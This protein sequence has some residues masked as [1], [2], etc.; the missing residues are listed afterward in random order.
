MAEPPM[1]TGSNLHAVRESPIGRRHVAIFLSGEDVD[2]GAGI[3]VSLA[4]FPGRG[5]RRPAA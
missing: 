5:E 1:T 4:A 3:S 2:P